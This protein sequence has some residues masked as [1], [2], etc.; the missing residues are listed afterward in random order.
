[1]QP[2]NQA[3]GFQFINGAKTFVDS[4]GKPVADQAGAQN[5]LYGTPNL[6]QTAPS[7]IVS[8][9]QVPINQQSGQAV[10]NGTSAIT[11]LGG[12]TPP[13]PAPQTTQ[14]G[15]QQT[16]T[17]EGNNTN[18]STQYNPSGNYMDTMNY[19]MGFLGQGVQAGEN[20]A[21][22]AYQTQIANA[23]LANQQLQLS[24]NTSL[25]SLNQQYNQSF[26]QLQTQHA[27]T[28]GAA[29]S[30]MSAADP[31]GVQS[32][33]FATGY[34]GKINDIYSQQSDF[35]T[36]A[37]GQ[38]QTALQNGEASAAIGIQQ[39]INQASA[40][41]GQQIASLQ[42]GLAQ[43]MQGIAQF[44]VTQANFQQSRT[45]QS[46]SN[47]DSF[48]KGTTLTGV[49]PDSSLQDLQA[50]YP[51]LFTEGQQAG[52]SPDD[53]AKSIRTGTVAAKNSQIAQ[54]RLYSE[55]G[56][57]AGGSGGGSSAA[58]ATLSPFGQSLTSAGG[59]AS[60]ANHPEITNQI[61]A[62]TSA[63]SPQNLSSLT[64]YVQSGNTNAITK[65]LGGLLNGTLGI[66][67]ANLQTAK[68]IGV[69]L[70]ENLDI[71]A[72]FASLANQSPTAR[73]AV[74]KSVLTSLQGKMQAKAKGLANTYNLGNNVEDLDSANTN[75]QQTI[76]SLGGASGSSSG[77]SAPTG[78]MSSMY[79]GMQGMSWSGAFGS[80]GD[81]FG[82]TK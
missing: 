20:A 63:A 69:Q 19:M 18:Q 52:F 9:A 59:S 58:N 3:A 65:V 60:I 77:S 15:G 30:Q 8:S 16:S 26:Q 12:P 73:A 39:Q 55:F 40:Q 42:M 41:Y 25:G 7:G 82:G 80:I 23:A 48:L 14:Q 71:G 45:L 1:M 43:S 66:N 51:T 38:Q 31:M 13:Q 62:I 27:N 49:N 79:S 53:V 57:G 67:M 32:S 35:L 24:Y 70:Q 4:G 46:Q 11:G 44:G 34:I 76:D 64:N 22:N 29:V 37:Y 21:G 28:V 47:F 17:G 33:S 10:S 50:S 74:I 2:N 6:G 56:A 68:D 54:E 5:F 61:T 78:S 36:Q 72:D 81:M 75:L